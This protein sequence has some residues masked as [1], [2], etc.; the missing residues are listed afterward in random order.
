MLLVH[1]PPVKLEEILALVSACLEY[2][3]EIVNTLRSLDLCGEL[4]ELVLCTSDINLSY[5]LAVEVIKSDFDGTT[6]KES[7]SA[8]CE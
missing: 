2:E 5:K 4:C 6:L 8:D 1:S 7:R 3:A